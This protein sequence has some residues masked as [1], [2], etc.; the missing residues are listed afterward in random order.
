[1]SKRKTGSDERSPEEAL[2]AR[3]LHDSGWFPAGTEVVHYGASGSGFAALS[4]V[5]PDL[6]MIRREDEAGITDEE[7]RR[8]LVHETR[9]ATLESLIRD[10]LGPNDRLDPVDIGLRVLTYAWDL[11]VPPVSRLTMEQIGDLAGQG[12]AAICERHKRQVQKKKERV[13]Q[14]GT[15][16]SRQKLE[17]DIRQYMESARGNANRR[18]SAAEGKV[19]KRRM[20][21]GEE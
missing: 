2:D 4:H 14:L 18:L 9:V 17:R 3:M 20:K 15:R 21:R 11:Q 8:R 1:M 5:S 16:S 10:L 6:E 12:R 13:G 19:A 7:E